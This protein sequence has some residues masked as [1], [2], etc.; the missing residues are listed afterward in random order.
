MYTYVHY[1]VFF[2]TLETI[3]TDADHL[4]C[5]NMACAGQP[6]YQAQSVWV[7]ERQ[8]LPDQPHLLLW[9]SDLLG[10]WGKVCWHS[11][12]RLQQSLWQGL[13][14]YSPGE[15]GSPWLGQVRFC[16]VKNWLNGQG[17]RVVVNG[18][19]S[20]WW[21]VL[22][23]QQLGWSIKLENYREVFSIFPY[24]REGPLDNSSITGIIRKPSAV[25]H[26]TCLSRNTIYNV[27]R[28]ERP[29]I[30]LK[31]LHGFKH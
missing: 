26:A 8:V 24:C 5:N 9:P 31:D 17:Q 15:G 6:G 3:Y 29:K 12:A 10:G 19:K 11:Q 4:E 18:V 14:W 2:H 21:L 16:W 22:S 28:L 25:T 30:I 20:R 27:Q 23:G 13:P 7:H 1:I